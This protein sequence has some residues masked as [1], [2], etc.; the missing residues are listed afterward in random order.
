MNTKFQFNYTGSF[1]QPPEMPLR[2]RLAW[3]HYFRG[4]PDWACSR[5]DEGCWIVT[6]KKN[7]LDHA[8]IFPDDEAFISWLD[9][10][11]REH[12]E[13]DALTFLRTFVLI[14]ELVDDDVVKAMKGVI[15][16]DS[17]N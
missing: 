2:A 15:D 14:D 5:T 12:L 16:N 17:N 9:N 8:Q 7:D 3:E 10:H 6:D 4:G 13:A 1:P 11:G